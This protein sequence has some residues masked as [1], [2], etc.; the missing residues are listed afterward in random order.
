MRTRFLI[1]TILLAWTM[2][3]AEVPPPDAQIAAA[4][5]AAPWIFVQVRKCWV[6]TPRAN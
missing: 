2:A 4:V 5:L 6:T 3:A 1:S